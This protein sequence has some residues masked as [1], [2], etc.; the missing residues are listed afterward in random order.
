MAFILLMMIRGLAGIIHKHNEFL[1]FEFFL[2]IRTMI[3]DIK[4]GEKMQLKTYFQEKQHTAMFQTYIIHNFITS[5]STQPR[6][7]M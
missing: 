1:N 5:C 3:N 2:R 4:V 7:N 6:Q